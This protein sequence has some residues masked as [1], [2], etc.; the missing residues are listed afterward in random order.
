MNYDQYYA[1]NNLTCWVCQ[2]L[3]RYQSHLTH[4]MNTSSKLNKHYK[5]SNPLY[6]TTSFAISAICIAIHLLASRDI[7]ILTRSK[8]ELALRYMFN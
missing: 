3:C 2:K 8:K 4:Y 6:S 7:F 1:G 5:S